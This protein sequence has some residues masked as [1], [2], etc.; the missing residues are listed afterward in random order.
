MAQRG[1]WRRRSEILKHQ[2]ADSVYRIWHPRHRVKERRRPSQYSL[3]PSFQWPRQIPARRPR[4]QLHPLDLAI[5]FAI[6]LPS[7]ENRTVCV[8]AYQINSLD[9]NKGFSGFDMILGDGFL[10]SVYAS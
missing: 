10:R 2:T 9:P 7:G 4:H 8:G 1:Q 6:T 3:N 5:P